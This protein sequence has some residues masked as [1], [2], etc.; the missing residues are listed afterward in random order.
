MRVD[1]IVEIALGSEFQRPK[2]IEPLWRRT[3]GHVMADSERASRADDA[4]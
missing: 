3:G 4:E 2:F 1:Q